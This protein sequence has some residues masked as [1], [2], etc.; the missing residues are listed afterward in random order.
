MLHRRI[1]PLLLA[2]ALLTGIFALSAS[3][4]GEEDQTMIITHINTASTTEGSAIVIAGTHTGTV[5]TKGTFAWWIVLVFDWDA[6]AGCFRLVE[7]N[8][9]T[10]SGADK[11]SMKIPHY[12]F[13]YGICVGNDYSPSGGINYITERVKNSYSYAQSLNVGDKAYLYGTHLAA[14][15]I[16]TNGK[17]WYADDFVSESYVK[18]G[19]PDA[20]KEAYDPI[21]AEHEKVQQR[22]ECNHVNS[23]HYA[24]GDCNLFLSDYA[25]YV[26]GDYSWWSCL[27]FAWD[28]SRESYVCVAVDQA[29]ANG[30]L[31][32][33]MIPENGFVIMDC[34]SAS[35]TAV[36]AVGVGDE[37]W[38]YKNGDNYSVCVNLPDETLTPVVPGGSM[39]METPE[40]EN[41]SYEGPTTKCT[42]D[43]FTIRWKEESAS[44]F[45]I[46]I[47][48]SVP[49]AFNKLVVPPT[50]VTG[51]SFTIE[52]GLLKAGSTYTVMLY[53]AG[54]KKLASVPTIARLFCVTEEA[55]ESSLADKTIVAFGDSLTA[56]S[57]WVSML[58]GFIG[59]EVINSGVGGDST[60]NAVARLQASVLDYKPDIALICFGMNDQ[61]QV[62]ASG[63]PNV[64]LETY[65]ENMETCVEAMQ[66]IGTEVIFICPHDAYDADGYYVP[67]EYGLN[68]AYGNM[69]LF[70]EAVR[71]M[72]I[73]YGCD[74]IDIY[75]ETQSE[76][77]SR[78][79]NKGDGI[80]QSVYGHEKWAEYVSKYL[81]AKYDG[82]DKAEIKVV[83]KDEAGKELTSYSFTAAKGASMTVPAKA[84]DGYEEKDA[85]QSIT[86]KGDAEIV[87]T[88]KKG[89]GV[90]YGDVNGD[91]G[92]DAFD[93]LML[94]AY[95]LGTYKN[96]TAEQIAAMHLNED[97]EIDAIDYFLLKR[98][99]LSQP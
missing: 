67:G 13:A 12:G 64:P 32:N 20:G 83:C 24:T 95:V 73:R 34:S 50:E 92:L 38:L 47:N 81:L 74:F 68:Y 51:Y 48:T 27:V 16:T 62:I 71:Q 10:G 97:G 96:A 4:Y 60:R 45:M 66:K 58:G 90:L 53:A 3:A 15:Q 84:L 14:G 80:H 35:K 49:N 55:M 30:N 42:P 21:E 89:E 94:K 87:Y 17:D 8:T 2:A 36:A 56:R 72:A 7:K 23:D 1:L 19:S 6:D 75:T 37:A 25:S 82:I 59:T 61:A 28:L 76:D 54:A 29:V 39:Q 26:K 70:C 79:L 43:G 31:K 46:A 86:V 9:T 40:F 33:P 41:L 98:L 52:K 44:K 5:G 85:E 91:G 78:F 18:I 57:G 77:M 99:I 11:S 93:Y 22:I 65:V 88:Y 63:K 69:K